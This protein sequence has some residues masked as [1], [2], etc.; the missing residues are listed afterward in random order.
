MIK[1]LTENIYIVK[2]FANNK[3]NIT[4]IFW[5]DCKFFVLCLTNM[6]RIINKSEAH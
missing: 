3:C 5:E 2:T 1:K 4:V 6:N